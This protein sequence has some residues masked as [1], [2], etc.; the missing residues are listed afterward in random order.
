MSL[1]SPDPRDLGP[2]AGRAPARDALL[3][4]AARYARWDGT[5]SIPALDADEIL[6]ALADDVMAEGDLA[7]ALRRLMERGWRAGDPTRPDLA[8]LNDLR[9][10]LRRQREELQERYQLRDV[11]ADVRQELEEIVAE[12]RAGIERRLDTAATPPEGT[13]V[14]PALRAMLRDAAARRLDELEA[15]P[16]DVGGRIRGLEAYD[17]MEPAARERFEALTE[18]LRRQTLDRFVEG[19]SE[20]IQGT[21]PEDLQANRDMVRDLN[22]LLEERL[23]GR[24]PSQSD[25][26]DFLANHGRFFPGARTLD[27]I[28]AQLTERMAA[29]QSLLRSMSPQQRAELQSMMDAL[30]RDDRLRWDLAR[31]ASNMDQL[32]PDGLGEGYEFSGDEPLGLEPA[33]DQ[34]GRLQALDALE[35]ALGDVEGPGDLADLDRDQVRELLGDESA[36]DLAALDELARQLE[37]AGYLT[38]RGEKLELTPRGSRRIG[39]KVLDDLFARLSRDAFGGHRIDRAGRGGER[40]ESTK[41]YEFGDPFHLDIRG[42]IENALRRPENAPGAGLRSGRGV[43]L[44]AADFEVFRTEQLTRTSTV[45]LVDMSRSML[46]RG[47]FLAAKKVAVA[48]DTLIRTQFPHDDLSVIGFAYYAR[49]L[50][51]ESLA[52]LTWHGYEYGTN[53]QHGLMLARQILARQ[54]GGT[55]QIVV[56]TDG[57]PT[58]HFENGQVEFSYP[59]TRRTIQETLRE[60]QRCTRDRITINTFMLERSRSLAEFVALITRMNRGRAFY[61]TP[62]HL[63]E[64]VLVDFVAGRTR[65]VG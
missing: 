33:L 53:L 19:L 64:Y 62:E 9:E 4:R 20:A 17:F 47:C 16:R 10:R 36:R 32:M 27:D 57:E 7:E 59:P 13:A 28:V 49:E 63:G 3:A 44:S 51:S 14:D 38:H 23:E 37:E 45:L 5:Q 60:V 55:R 35:D 43:S 22:S 54:R 52:E 58:A 61:A 56:I 30:L 46:L 2:A 48:L 1:F 8:G 12:E 40:E 15:L 11:L 41:P 21:T 65:G 24:E 6:D 25:V 39:Q 31:L 18:R 26:D 34:I 50:R 42:T 29:M